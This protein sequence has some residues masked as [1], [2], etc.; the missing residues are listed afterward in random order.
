MELGEEDKKEDVDDDDAVKLEMHE[1][2]HD[3]EEL[4]GEDGDWKRK[5]EEM[6]SD[7]EKLLAMGAAASRA[8]KKE[9][10]AMAD[11]AWRIAMLRKHGPRARGMW[12]P[13][14]ISRSSAGG[15]ASTQ[16]RAA[17]CLRC[18]EGLSMGI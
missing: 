5:L 14:I 4:K 9:V 13:R 8:L 7:Y 2:A 1:D 12:T 10:I 3:S 16:G 18:E 6:E 11:M 15:K 17:A